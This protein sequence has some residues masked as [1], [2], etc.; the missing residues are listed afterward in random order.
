L[1]AQE[2]TVMVYMMADNDLY[3]YAL[4]DLNEL[5]KASSGSGVNF[6]V[7]IDSDQGTKRLAVRHNRIEVLGYLGFLNSGDPSVLGEFGKWA[8]ESYPAKQ[9]SLI[10]WDHGNGWSKKSKYIGYDNQYAD[11]LSV[12]DGELRQAISSISSCI[13]RPIDIV[14]F[15]AC[16]MQC[17]EVL[18]EL[19]DKARFV[20]GSQTTFPATGIPYNIAFAGL[21]TLTPEMVSRQ[22]VNACSMAY[23]GTTEIAFSAVDVERLSSWAEACKRWINDNA[24]TITGIPPAII[25]SV[26][27]FPLFDA[28]DA[29]SIF[30]KFGTYIN[31]PAKT[32]WLLLRDSLQKC[33]I[34]NYGSSFTYQNASGL[35][36]WFPG[37]EYGFMSLSQKYWQLYWTRNSDWDIVIGRFLAVKDYEAP[38]VQKINSENNIKGAKLV[39]WENS[40][41]F[42]RIQKYQLRTI[43]INDTLF[44]D[45]AEDAGERGF[46]L[47]GF[48]VVGQNRGYKSE[49][50]YFS[51]GGSLVSQVCIDID[52]G[53][54]VG[55][56]IKG[57][58]GECS[59]LASRDTLN[60]WDTAGIYECYYDTSWH[61]N[62][63]RIAAGRYWLKFDWKD[64][65]T[66]WVYLDNISSLEELTDSSFEG[67]T[68][69][70]FYLLPEAF[71]KKIY[72]IRSFDKIGNIGEWSEPFT[73]SANV[74]NNVKFWPN[75]AH[76]EINA[77]S[78]FKVPT[79]P[80]LDIYNI[81]GQRIASVDYRYS[82]YDVSS[83]NYSY[84]FKWNGKT[85]LNTRVA[86]GVYWGRVCSEHGIQIG[87]FV[88]LK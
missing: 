71:T 25:D 50:S 26:Q 38:I 80:R 65:Y 85:D 24:S 88:W 15:D 43:A 56:F 79:Y 31:G 4:G 7:Q 42:S 47:N 63:A 8:V 3:S 27:A 6:I 1:F 46:T 78:C 5:Q 16:G 74:F 86:N 61:Y 73:V 19:K 40:Y 29:I 77:I 22:I 51:T 44:Y 52:S 28:C 35:S 81:L 17:A 62:F 12:A 82:S 75:P 84:F 41:D 18:F 30:D 68:Q 72:Q 23:D 54:G 67:E 57:N 87:R 9:Y 58:R 66:G 53:G 14:G 37:N 60:G 48:S 13:G 36:V 83:S 70:T 20:V 11:Y 69:D 33:V 2:W 49:Y 76:N 59:L 64:E 21:E 34:T 45:G 10:L 55:W 32:E 39:F